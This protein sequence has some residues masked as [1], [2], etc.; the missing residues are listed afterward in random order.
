M[1]TVAEASKDICP[2]FVLYVFCAKIIIDKRIKTEAKN[3][4]IAK[5]F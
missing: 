4:F 2:V 1:S 3:I 5:I